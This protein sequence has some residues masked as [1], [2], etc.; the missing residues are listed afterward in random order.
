MTAELTSPHLTS[1][2]APAASMGNQGR[3]KAEFSNRTKLKE[4]YG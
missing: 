2:I 4:M 1:H 3:Q